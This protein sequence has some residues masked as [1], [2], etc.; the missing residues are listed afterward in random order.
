MSAYF[1]SLSLLMQES[2][3]YWWVPAHMQE[4]LQQ[5]SNEENQ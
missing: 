5:I 2:V 4:T 3:H 1:Y